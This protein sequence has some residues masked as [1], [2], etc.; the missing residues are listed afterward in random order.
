MPAKKP[1]PK[2]TAA[3]KTPAK[4]TDAKKPVA[5]KSTPKKEVAPKSQTAVIDGTI[6]VE[7]EISKSFLD[8]AM[9]V[10]VSRALPDVKDGLK[11]VQRR[12]LYSMYETGIRPTGP[13]RKCS[14]V[15]GDVMGNYHPHGNDAIYGT[16]VRLGQHFSTRYP[17][18]EP[19]GNFGTPDDPPAA[20]RY[21]ESR[22]SSLSSQLLDGIDEE[23][24][25]F[26][27][28]YSGETSEPKVLPARF[29]NLLVN[30]AEGIA[31]AM[32]TN[33]PPYNL[34]EITEAVKF[35]IENKNVKPKDYLKIIKGPDFPTGGLVV[36]TP[37][38]KDAILKGRGSIKL[39]AVADVEELGKGRSAII[40]KELPYQASIDRIME[41]IASLV[42][43]KKLVGISDLRNESSD[44]N[45][46]RLVVEL[47]RDAVPQV[48]LNQLFKQTQLQDS[49]S[50]NSVALVDGVPKIL[51]V[52]ELISLY[53]EHQIDVI[54]RRT[55]YRL[56]KAEDR[57]HIVEGLL[58]AL[59][60]IDQIIKV[61]K[62]SKDVET[63]R[64]SLMTKFKLSEIQATHIL[65][66]PL[67]RLTALELEKLKEEKDQLKNTIKE[68]TSILKSKAK[69]EGILIEELE[70]ITKKFG[71]ERRSRI[72]PDVGEVSIEDLI[73]DEEIIVSVS[74]AGYIKS[75]PST[76][77]KK[78]GRGG[79]GV[80]AASSE[81][82]VI[83]HLLSTSVHSYLLFFTDKGK[84]YRAKAH[85]IPK[86]T[87]TAKGSLVQNVLSMGQDEKIQAII[88]TRDYETEKFLL[89]MTEKG[90]IK[91]SNFKEFD[92]NYKSLQA[93]K[94]KDDDQVVSVKTTSG[95]EDVILVSQNGQAIRFDE[96]N[97][98]PQGRT[99]M[100]VR[101]IKL[102]EGDKVV[103]AATSRDETLLFITAKGYGKRTK[104]DE[105]RKAGRGGMGVK[106]LKVTETKGNL[107]GAR[108]V[109]EDTEVMLMSTGGTAIRCAVKQIKKMSRAAQGVRIMKLSKEEE[110][111]AFIPIKSE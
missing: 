83:E 38:I 96:T 35:T 64:K 105:F 31:V 5:K 84:V 21:T 65:D 99:A 47:K 58:L 86:T 20:M 75:V 73:E 82:D 9:S 52:P 29:P 85:E 101:G 104:L 102:R 89:I 34:R 15:V 51:S 79:K 107:V 94:L 59:N 78:Q 46:T 4:K 7:D 26:E 18:I 67:R 111:S 45:G 28:N 24:V 93:I 91:K 77:Y 60:K 109:D 3:K 90:T 48:V 76:S 62:A 80:K 108:S 41:K 97:L 17:L 1:T 103:G 92:S 106:A 54:Q 95:K 98:K 88:D 70:A 11:P 53:I 12:I 40:V 56:K 69:Q 14:K 100:G 57:L 16:L 2:K 8:Y 110:I 39:R 49:F 81:E 33:M 66:M 32:A 42:Q 50:V 55:K 44:R 74:A 22:M 19:Q 63:A 27:P 25:D 61:I 43:D 72:V 71:D 13:F 37:T 36:D 68:L 30:G 6:A 87:R 10:I 23:T